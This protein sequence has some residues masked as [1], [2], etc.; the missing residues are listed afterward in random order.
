MNSLTKW[1][2]SFQ[3]YSSVSSLIVKS[4]KSLQ[5][6]IKWR[7]VISIPAEY[8]VI[9]SFNDICNVFVFRIYL[10]WCLYNTFNLGTCFES[11]L[12]LCVFG[13]G[14]I[15]RLKFSLSLNAKL[16]FAL[17]TIKCTLS[18]LYECL[19]YLSF[20]APNVMNIIYFV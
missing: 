2:Y 7:T 12:S 13:F 20:D 6:E 18:Y 4:S 17:N 10:S 14:L 9:F 11:F 5:E 19:F 16:K 3:K 1:V 8:E 15:I